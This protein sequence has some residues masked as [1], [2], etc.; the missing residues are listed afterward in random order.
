MMGMRRAILYLAAI[1]VLGVVVGAL[2]ERLVERR[3]GWEHQSWQERRAHVVDRF[4]KELNLTPQQRDQLA[5]ILDE[6]GQQYQALHEQVRQQYNAI[7]Q[8]GRQRIREILTPEQ[9]TR[10]EEIVKKLDE[11][12]RKDGRRR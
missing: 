11:E 12:R 2:G 6:T 10:F 4:T 1:F 8:S 7:R 9:R 3:W 5:R